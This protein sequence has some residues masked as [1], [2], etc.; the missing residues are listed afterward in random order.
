MQSALHVA[1]TGSLVHDL[2]LEP[3]R[4]R[5]SLLEAAGLISV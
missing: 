2:F 1:R 4:P 5:R 3:S